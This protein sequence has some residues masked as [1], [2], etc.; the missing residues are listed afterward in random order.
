MGPI[1]TRLADLNPRERR[2]LVAGATTLLAFFLYLLVSTGGPTSVPEESRDESPPPV[3]AFHQP[4]SEAAPPAPSTLPP[5]ASLSGLVLRGVLGGGPRGGTAIIGFPDGSQRSVPIGRQVLPGVTLKE[6]ALRHVILATSAGESRLEFDK[7]A[8]EIAPTAVAAAAS[9]ANPDR[10][11]ETL[12]FRT[13]LMPLKEDGRIKGFAIRPGAQLAIFQRAGL[14]P[15]DVIVSIN[16]QA[17]RSE[18]KVLELSAELASARTIEI[19]FIRAGR[20]MTG[21]VEQNSSQR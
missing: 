12:E 17:F 6:V 10:R 15:G 8:R 7:A 11:R 13:G 14:K 2:F 19:A 21:K 20:R 18:E 16:G 1:A 3:P 4:S 9:E 5:A